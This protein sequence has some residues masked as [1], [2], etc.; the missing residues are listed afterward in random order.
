M[1]R[2]Y[3][4]DPDRVYIAGYSGGGRVASSL[5]LLYP[6]VFRG[7]AFFFGSNYFRKV[8]VPGQPGAFWRA[9]FPAPAKGSMAKLRKEHHFVLIAGE[10]DFNREETEA[11]STEYRRDR[12]KNVTYLEIPGAD[13]DY[14]VHGEWL[15]RVLEALD[16]P[17]RAD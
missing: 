10:H 3:N 12:F 17:S 15:K 1:Q 11:Y 2:L 4:I 14:G 16:L 9:G 8:E 7:G 5:A 13:H 6:E